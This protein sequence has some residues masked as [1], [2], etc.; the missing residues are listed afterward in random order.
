MKISFLAGASPVV[1]STQ[2]SLALY[3]ETLGVPF[4][5]PEGDYPATGTLDGSKHFGLWNLRDAAQS[6][7]G[8][9]TWPEDRIKP[10]A[11]FE[12]DVESAEAVATASE[13]L[14]AKGYELLVS[15]RTEPWGQVVTRMQSPEGLLVC[16]TFTPWMHNDGA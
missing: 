4:A 15:A 3:Y 16:V 8:A 14:S 2:E 11:C 7:F 6:C 10:Q 1:A 9:D 5:D 13:E 12:F